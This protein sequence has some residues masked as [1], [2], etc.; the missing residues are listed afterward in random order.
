MGVGVPSG[1]RG[2]GGAFDRPGQDGLFAIPTLRNVARTAPYMHDGSLATL[3]EVVE[4]YRRGGGR[5]LGVEPG[6]IHEHVR[7]FEIGDDEARDLVAFLHALTAESA[8]PA[9]PETVPSGL[10]VLAERRVA[11]HEESRP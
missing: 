3:E 5:P 7:P 6:R 9:V 8:R 10:P 4:F 2:V 11:S 1:D